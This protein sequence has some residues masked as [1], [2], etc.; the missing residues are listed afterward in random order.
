MHKGL[1]R[2]FVSFLILLSPVVLS[3]AAEQS[4]S[5][6]GY[7]PVSYFTKNKAEKGLPEFAV[8]HKE[9]TYYLTSAEQVDIFKTNP[10]KYTPKFGRN[11]AFSLTLGRKM[12]IDPTN[13]KVLGDFL[14]LFHKSDE[15]NGL[16]QWN[17]A[18]DEK[19]LVVEAEK[20]F[21]LLKFN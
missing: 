20:Q 8:T 10:D 19:K 21:T 2:F 18:K 6:E 9:K 14:L 7:S 15:V 3:K 4:V 13:F 16:D 12:S 11:C 1:I 17:K 5:I